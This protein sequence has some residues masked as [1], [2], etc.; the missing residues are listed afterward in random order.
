[1]SAPARS[2][3]EVPLQAG[4][5]TIRLTKRE[6]EALHLVLAL[7]RERPEALHDYAGHSDA[8]RVLGG[9]L[10]RI[11]AKLPARGSGCYG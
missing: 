4:D 6:R 11:Q 2:R 1:M 3:P 8:A 5:C 7:A 10:A 9:H